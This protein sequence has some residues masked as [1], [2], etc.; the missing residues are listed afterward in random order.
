MKN[1]VFVLLFI[2]SAIFFQSAQPVTN[3][4]TNTVEVRQLSKKELKKEIR[5]AVKDNNLGVFMG[6]FGILAIIVGGIALII[7]LFTTIFSWMWI[8]LLLGFVSLII[9]ASLCTVQ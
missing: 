3:V 9:G 6:F 1:V 2:V 5:K 8:T 7:G 4:S